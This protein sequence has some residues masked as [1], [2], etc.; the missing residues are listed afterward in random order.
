MTETMM[1]AR[2]KNCAFGNI[3]DRVI[4][5]DN[6]DDFPHKATNLRS[7]PFY[8]GDLTLTASEDT[9]IFSRKGGIGE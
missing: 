1:M 9:R 5:N 7:F 4:I 8:V 6:H 2:Q 3:L